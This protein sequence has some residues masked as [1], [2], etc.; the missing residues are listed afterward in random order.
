M[1]PNT[2]RTKGMSYNYTFSE[3][4]VEKRVQCNT[5]NNAMVSYLNDKI[6]L[7][8][9][10]NSH[11]K[12]EIT[13]KS[14]D[15]EMTEYYLRLRREFFEDAERNKKE[16]IL[17]EQELNAEIEKLKTE[18]S[19]LTK[20]IL[21][22]E[23]IELKISR[24]EDM[25]FRESERSNKFTS[26]LKNAFTK[27]SSSKT[28][29]K[30]F[31]NFYDNEFASNL[32]E[33]NYF[34]GTNNFPQEKETNIN[35]DTLY[36]QSTFPNSQFEE[37]RETQYK[38]EK[39]SMN[40]QA[41]NESPQSNHYIV[42]INDLEERL[43]LVDNFLKDREKEIDNLNDIKANNTSEFERE[44]DNLKMEIEKIKGKYLM[45]LTSKKSMSEE[46]Q[47]LFEKQ[48]ENYKIQSDKTIYELEK[49]IINLEKTNEN[50]EKEIQKLTQMSSESVNDKQAE[51]EN[52]KILIRN[53]IE[54]Y[55]Q[56]Y[57][58]Y[59][60]NLK[61]L[62]K[63][64]DSMR[65]LYAAR[66]NEFINLTNY[67]L[68]TINDYSK[69]ISE[70][71][72][73]SN[74]KKIEEN[75][76]QQTRECLELKQKLENFVKEISRLQTEVIDTKSNIRQKVCEA[77]RNYDENIEKIINGHNTLENKLGNIF[78]FMNNFE[79]KFGFFN[80]LIEDKKKLEAMIESLECEIK[81]SSQEHKDKE[82]FSLK[83]EIVKL[84]KDNEM[85]NLIIRE[86]EENKN[87]EIEKT[88]APKNSKKARDIVPEET[89]AKLRNE[90]TI[91]S[92]QVTNLNK[93]KESI[94]KFYQIEISNLFEK[95]K[96]KNEKM[97]E[98]KSIIKKM[99]SDFSGKKETVFNL[100]ML[101]FKEFKNNLITIAEIKELIENFKIN[102]EELTVHKDRIYNE[103]LYLLRQEM[104]VK[105]ELVNSLK[106]NFENERKNLVEIIE[107][108][109]KT[110]DSKVNLYDDL[111][112]QK[113]KEFSVLR[114]E[115]ERLKGV[116]LSKAKVNY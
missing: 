40:L 13:M 25:L 28:S 78:T 24:D 76:V 96:E 15:R 20:R 56:V 73:E 68:D 77:M 23:Q 44:K 107:T 101:E 94:E 63:Q 14:N 30:Y 5:D 95:I 4:S 43:R 98:L 62:T 33:E 27:T 84:Q 113:K 92:N 51:M 104:K 50:Y 75:Y 59:E 42:I 2:E 53:I 47:S 74:V 37:N 48:I 61:S 109:K 88:F 82:I 111:I 79:E 35:K 102:G 83:E 103:E 21:N 115:K 17:R 11:L 116:E 16:R 10:E 89:I 39:E 114:N 91:L 90:I 112:N 9:T 41:V 64:M 97:D 26:G 46:Y 80:T 99:N 67:Y 54:N 66:E 106:Q 34:S 81:M 69:P 100:W 70:I 87:F 12:K 19:F 8:E 31:Q 72:S 65:Q 57:K 105:D 1:L 6:Q 55:E 38:K 108:F 60:E 3:N 58:N 45:V 36:F 7:L 29:G 49:K 86:H 93:T 52:V 22:M 71:T 18:N 85:M 110:I 32:M